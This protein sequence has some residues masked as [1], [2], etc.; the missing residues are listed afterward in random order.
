MQIWT[1]NIR[2]RAGRIGWFRVK[3]LN[4][5]F[6]DMGGF[7]SIRVFRKLLVTFS[8]NTHGGM[9]ITRVL[10]VLTLNNVM[11]IEVGTMQTS[12]F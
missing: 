9:T 7:F 10:S 1:L 8:R 12:P 6:V 2:A 4:P 5:S 11:E 3:G